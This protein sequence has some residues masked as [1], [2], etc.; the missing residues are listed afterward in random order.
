MG[1]NILTFEKERMFPIS[2]PLRRV[3]RLCSSGGGETR[4]HKCTF[5]SR[6]F[7]RKDHLKT[8]IRIHTGE[9]PYKCKICGRG[10]IQ[11]QQIIYLVP[12]RILWNI[13]RRVKYDVP[14]SLLILKSVCK[15]T[16]PRLSYEEVAIRNVEYVLF[17]LLPKS[18]LLAVVESLVGGREIYISI[19]KLYILHKK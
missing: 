12:R 10:F 16:S 8:H 5:C 1:F 17:F 14:D 9:R 4:I 3:D 13:L 19:Y 11:S 18:S 6:K 15:V 7:K 2:D